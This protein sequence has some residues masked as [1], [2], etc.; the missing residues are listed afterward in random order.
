MNVASRIHSTVGKPWTAGPRTLGTLVY[1]RYLIAR[2]LPS[3][4]H[5]EVVVK[6][7]GGGWREIGMI[8]KVGS[9][10]GKP[11]W[12]GVFDEEYGLDGVYHGN[13]VTEV[14]EAMGEAYRGRP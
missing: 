8:E 5:W 14:L 4:R 6:M 7:T 13:T 12:A 2:E 10:P 9:D 11:P 3:E 1:D